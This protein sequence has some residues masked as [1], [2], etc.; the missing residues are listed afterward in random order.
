MANER[1]SAEDFVTAVLSECGRYPFAR[2]E[3][4]VVFDHACTDGTFAALQAMAE[5]EPR[6]RIIWAPDNR[7]VVDAYLRGYKEALARGN[8]WI[9]EID[10]GFSHEPAQ[11]PLFFAEMAKPRDCVFGVR[12][13]RKGAKFSGNLKRRLI[14]WGGSRLTNLLL[15]TR[16]SDMTSGFELF[17]RT[18]LQFI[19]EQGIHSRGPFFQTEIRTH[20]HALNIAAAP[21][22]YRSPSHAI[23]KHALLDALKVLRLMYQARKGMRLPKE[24]A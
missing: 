10:A 18:S 21:I 9:L 22:Y 23:G 24:A 13:G 5:K 20:A 3:M 16:L 4:Y 7:C 8:D 11:I 1:Q 2:I 12:F 19:L 15:G 6:L 14:S 17:S